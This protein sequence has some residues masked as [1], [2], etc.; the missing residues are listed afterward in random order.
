MYRVGD[1]VDPFL[2]SEV[3]EY[4]GSVPQQADTCPTCR[5]LLPPSCRDLGA[6]ALFSLFG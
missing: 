6:P 3:A 2:G 4:P 5:L 1:I